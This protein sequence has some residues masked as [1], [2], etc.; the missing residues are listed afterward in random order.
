M[1]NSKI[2]QVIVM[3]INIQYSRP[4]IDMV[5]NIQGSNYMRNHVYCPSIVKTYYICKS[6]IRSKKP[7]CIILL[8]TCQ[9]LIG[10]KKLKNDFNTHDLI[11]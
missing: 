6:I 11:Q 2:S 4:I 3:C 1:I 7:P 5:M 9:I 10:R 8:L